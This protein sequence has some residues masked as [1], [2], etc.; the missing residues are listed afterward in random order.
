MD[1]TFKIEVNNQIERV[2]GHL[3]IPKLFLYP[4]NSPLVQR[5]LDTP[6]RIQ[7]YKHDLVQ[8]SSMICLQDKLLKLMLISLSEIQ[9]ISKSFALL[10]YI[11]IY[12]D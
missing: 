9:R 8:T 3:F 7:F 4:R 12:I 2:M 11:Y 6:L 5:D 10:K 1:Q